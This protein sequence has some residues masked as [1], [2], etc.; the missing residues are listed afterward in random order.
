MVHAVQV[1]QDGLIDAGPFGYKRMV[2]GKLSAR[3]GVNPDLGPIL[4]PFPLRIDGR[5]SGHDRPIQFLM[6][7]PKPGR[8]LVV[9]I[10]QRALFEATGR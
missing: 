3:P 5:I 1:C 7:D 6:S 4:A 10:R 8:P 9:K 2:R